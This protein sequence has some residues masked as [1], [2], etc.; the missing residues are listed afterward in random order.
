MPTPSRPPRQRKSAAALDTAEPATLDQDQLLGLVGYNCRQTYLRISPVFAKRMAKHSLRPAEYSVITL[1][2]A[3]P[4]INQKRL[5]EAINVS[6]PNLATLLDRLE[7][8]GL[9]ARVRNPADKRSQTLVLT[10]EGQRLCRK[11]DKTV[12]ELEL[13]ATAMLSDEE[14]GE[15]LRLLQKVFLQ[16]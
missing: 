5:S 3:N 4:N 14:R 16:P 9:L 2:N 11:A 10:P 13:E 12:Q 6:P 7:Q 15:L 1:V 8:R